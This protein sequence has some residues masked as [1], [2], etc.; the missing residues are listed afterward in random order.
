[1]GQI[2]SPTVFGVEEG[3]LIE[4]KIAVP[5]EPSNASDP[6]YDE[7]EADPLGGSRGYF[8]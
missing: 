6:M 7:I 5:H 3:I 2:Q 8:V 1:M 4:K